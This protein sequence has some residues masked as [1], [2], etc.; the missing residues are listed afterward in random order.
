MARFSLNTYI[1]HSLMLIMALLT[2]AVCE[3]GHEEDFSIWLEMANNG[4]PKAMRI[5]GTSYYSGWGTDPDHS[6]AVEWYL[7][8]AL[9]GDAE[10]MRH[11]GVM[12]HNGH[13]VTRDRTFARLLYVTAVS[14]GYEAA[15]ADIEILDREEAGT[16]APASEIESPENQESQLEEI[17]E[18]LR[19]S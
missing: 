15:K 13:G 10:A 6:L 2:P 3:A 7:K 14:H 8:A 1:L 9:A 5:V 18:L 19:N 11:L 16:D 17:I 4:D 12:F